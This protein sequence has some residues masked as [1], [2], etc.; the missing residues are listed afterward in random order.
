MSIDTH[1]GRGRLREL[2]AVDP[3]AD[4]EPAGAELLI[5]LFLVC[6]EVYVL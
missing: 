6:V 4:E 1:L 3:F 2:D 5:D